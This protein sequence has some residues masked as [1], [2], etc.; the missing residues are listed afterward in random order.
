MAVHHRS[1][2]FAPQRSDDVTII[3]PSGRWVSL[4]LDELWQ[5]RELLCF[6]IWRDL[7]VRYKQTALGAAWAII[8]PLFTMVVFSIFFGYLGHIPSDGVPYPVFAYTALV[9]WTYFAN[10]LAHASNSLVEHERTITKI[11]FPR[12]MLPLASVVAGLVD[13]AIA[14]V[15]L[16]GMMVFY[17]IVPTV[18]IVWVPLLILLATMTA[19]AVSLW[20]AAANVRYRDVRYALPFL[21]QFWM[22]ATPVVYPSSLLPDNWRT[23]YALNPMVGVIEGFRWALLGGVDA[24][25]LVLAASCA[26]V[27]GVLL[28]GMYWFRRVEQTFADIV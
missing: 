17:G 2:P 21:I 26:A 8:Q 6:L 23:V 3:R 13:F 4:G 28:T 25:S 15:V 10:A 12:L 1:G 5:R 11:Y 20:L 19:F 18:A 9:P 7:K 14:F 16:M 22:F 24:P 27:T